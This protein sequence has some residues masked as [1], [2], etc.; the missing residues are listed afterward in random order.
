MNGKLIY[1]L[2]A[3]NLLLSIKGNPTPTFEWRLDGRFMGNGKTLEA[4]VSEKDDRK[5]LECSALH[6][7]LKGATQRVK[8]TSQIRVQCE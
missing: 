1:S 4:K 7:P 8:T 6:Q 2:F 5:V 3:F